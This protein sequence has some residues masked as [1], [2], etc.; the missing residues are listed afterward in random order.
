LDADDAF[1]QILQSQKDD[2]TSLLSNMDKSLM[3]LLIILYDEIDRE[4]YERLQR[5]YYDYKSIFGNI[6]EYSGLIK[7]FFPSS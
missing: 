5:K 6:R 4:K 3:D 2:F 1:K 7:N